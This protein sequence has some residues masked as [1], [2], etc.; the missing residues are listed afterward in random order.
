MRIYIGKHLAQWTISTQHI[1]VTM[2]P[3]A[4]AVEANTPG[5]YIACHVQRAIA[6][7]YV[8]LEYKKQIKLGT[9]RIGLGKYTEAK[10]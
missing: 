1:V 10:F 9:A 5:A 8:W 7:W 6:I 2:I 4:K 3:E